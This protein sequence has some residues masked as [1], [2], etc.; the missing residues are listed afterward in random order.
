MS[1]SEN[2]NETEEVEINL[3]AEEEFDDGKEKEFS[4]E[5]ITVDFGEAADSMLEDIKAESSYVPERETLSVEDLEP[6]DVSS[7]NVVHMEN[8]AAGEARGQLTESADLDELQESI[9]IDAGEP[10]FE[11]VES[12]EDEELQAY[13]SRKRLSRM[14]VFAIIILLLLAG[15]TGLFIWRN[16]TPPD[17]K[18][19]DSDALQTSSAGAYSTQFQPIDSEDV[20]GL[21][22]FFGKTPEQV[23]EE[24][25]GAIT[26]DG[27]AAPSSDSS[28]PNV[29]STRTGR[30]A[31]EN[32]QTL[33]NLT[34]G[35][36][37][38]GVI[39]YVFAS[40]DL[41]AFGVADSK[42]DELASSNVVAA[43]VLTGAGLDAATVKDAQLTIVE[44][45]QAVISRDGSAQEVARFSGPTNI[46]GV[47]TQWTLT[48]TYDHTAGV[49][50]GDN[51][52]IRSLSVDL[53]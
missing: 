37:A 45:P 53:R 39:S 14:L 41:D 30:F 8:P 32:G 31:A 21:V 23:A 2:R 42:F 28:L 26:L 49:T 11:Y 16:S 44:N 24:S 34:F 38:E 46:G 7:D 10:D 29:A 48:E 19:P 43:S 17:V 33:V 40:F 27:A 9:S 4:D 12:E 52:V 15:V 25:A 20:P 35:M 51:S 13:K 5:A 47:P 22:S 18:K 50:I 6:G 3:F 1:E 36:N